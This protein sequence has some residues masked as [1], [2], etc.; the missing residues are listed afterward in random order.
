MI[1]VQM[2]HSSPSPQGSEEAIQE[3]KS[4]LRTQGWVGI[5]Q[6]MKEELG[7]E[8]CSTQRSQQ[9]QSLRGLKKKK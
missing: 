1:R 5:I 9:E 4:K 3:V 7:K 8:E 6:V 2:E